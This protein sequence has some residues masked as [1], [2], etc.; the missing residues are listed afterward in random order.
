MDLHVIFTIAE[1]AFKRITTGWFIRLL[2]GGGIF[3]LY[4]LFRG[5]PNPPEVELIEARSFTAWLIGMVSML[6]VIVMGST[7]IPR[8]IDTRTI[9]V[10]LSKPLTKADIVLGKFFG[11][12]Y[13]ALFT[14]LILSSVTILGSSV[15]AALCEIDVPPDVHFLQ[16]IFLGLFQ[17]VLVASVV[18]FLSTMLSEIPIIF[19]T[20]FYVLLGYLV[21]YIQAFMYIPAFPKAAKLALL[22]VY[23]AIPNLRYLEIPNEVTCLETISWTH[24]GLSFI[25]II[26]YSVFFLIMGLRSFDKREVA[27]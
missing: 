19:F 26:L 9:L 14:T 5:G 7:E 3:I 21:A 6:L 1:Y 23:Y 17:S 25:Y 15:Q 12:V 11:L 22:A 27:G 18:I 24:F 4:M 8:D 10:I 20:A 13:V 2:L 16:K